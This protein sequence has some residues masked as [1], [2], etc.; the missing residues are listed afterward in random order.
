MAIN[1]SIAGPNHAKDDGSCRIT[2]IGNNH[3]ILELTLAVKL[4][5]Q[6]CFAG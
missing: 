2:S 1:S 5:D 4:I 3:A 6:R